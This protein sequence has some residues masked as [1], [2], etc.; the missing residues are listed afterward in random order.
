MSYKIHLDWFLFELRIPDE[1]M[2]QHQPAPYIRSVTEADLPAIAQLAGVIWRAHYPG[3]ISREQIEYML[4]KMYSLETLRDEIL[5]GGVRHELLLVGDEWAGF[6]ALG[7]TERSRQFKLHK[8]YLS[9]VWQGQGMGS[10]LLRHCE[11][12]ARKL[13]A[14]HLLLTVNKRNAKAIDAYKRNG[15]VITKSVVMDIGGGFVM[16]DYVM[17]K[18]LSNLTVK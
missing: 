9:Q 3:I 4:D 15:F 8:L 18:E 5:L 10:M 1:N 7:P 6:A 16:D 2:N 13:G 12:E 17:N 11:H 14:D